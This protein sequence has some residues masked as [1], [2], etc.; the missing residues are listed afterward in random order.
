[1]SKIG[2][3]VIE[4]KDP[5]KGL[6]GL[7]KNLDLKPEQ[8]IELIIMALGFEEI[9]LREKQRNV[10]TEREFE[11]IRE[12]KRL[13]RKQKKEYQKIIWFFCETCGKKFKKSRSLSLHKYALHIAPEDE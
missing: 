8:A 5:E 1:M 11:E 7:Y 10:D 3:V 2:A 6:E 12:E 4:A 13:K 9:N